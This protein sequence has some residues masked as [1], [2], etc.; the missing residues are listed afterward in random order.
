MLVSAQIFL[1]WGIISIHNQCHRPAVPFLVCVVLPAVRLGESSPSESQ[2]VILSTTLQWMVDRQATGIGHLG[3]SWFQSDHLYI[4]VLRSLS[5]RYHP[6]N[7]FSVDGHLP[8]SFCV[9]LQQTHTHR[10]TSKAFC[11]GVWVLLY[12]IVSE[13]FEIRNIIKQVFI[14]NTNRKH[15]SV[16]SYDCAERHLLIYSQK[17]TAFICYTLLIQIYKY[18]TFL[19][20]IFPSISETLNLK[21]CN[22]YCFCSFAQNL[23]R[24]EAVC[25]QSKLICDPNPNL[26]MNLLLSCIGRPKWLYV[27]TQERL[28]KRVNSANF[29]LAS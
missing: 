20:D 4:L 2:S 11:T 29:Q 13:I 17:L 5:P 22:Y 10:S 15:F 6:P 23:I 27:E 8:G 19:P 9:G 16:T 12:V 25:S 21:T 28:K 26:F 18:Y 1:G 14:K 3:L 7:C 24:S